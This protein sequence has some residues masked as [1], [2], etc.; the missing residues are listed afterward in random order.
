LS[1]DSSDFFSAASSFAYAK[2]VVSGEDLEVV[3]LKNLAT[4]DQS[5]TAAAYAQVSALGSGT[6]TIVGDSQKVYN[7]VP[8]FDTNRHVPVAAPTVSNSFFGK[9]IA[10][11]N[12]VDSGSNTKWL[13][14]VTSKEIVDEFDFDGADPTSILPLLAKGSAPLIKNTVQINNG[15]FYLYSA[16]DNFAGAADATGVTNFKIGADIAASCFAA[17]TGRDSAVTITDAKLGYGIASMEQITPAVA[18]LQIDADG[19]GVAN[20]L[21]ITAEGGVAAALSSYCSRR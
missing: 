3:Y 2:G 6:L 21:Q 17:G 7:A 15:K 11:N 18:Y 5:K 13:A 16:T 1:A 14:A 8:A 12:A 10:V 20:G 19:T 9:D 4:N